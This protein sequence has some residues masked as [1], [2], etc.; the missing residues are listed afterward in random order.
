MIDIRGIPELQSKLN[1]LDDKV[2]K[3]IV[4][5]ALK[6]AN[7]DI[8]MPEVIFNMPSETGAMVAGVKIVT[9]G[10]K[11]VIRSKVVSTVLNEKGEGYTGFDELGTKYQG[12]G[13]EFMR[14]AIH[15]NESSILENVE[16]S[17]SQGILQAATR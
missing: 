9:G 1:K 2:Q 13:L 16:G 11:S 14:K 15:D 10:G 8:V 6:K 4:K 7:Q 12:D 5:D 17:L 3:T